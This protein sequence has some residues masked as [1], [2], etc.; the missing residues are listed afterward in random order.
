M[1]VKAWAALSLG[2]QAPLAQSRSLD[3]V[4]VF[5]G[6]ELAAKNLCKTQ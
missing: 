2:F 5:L 3:R 1:T 4:P 6:I